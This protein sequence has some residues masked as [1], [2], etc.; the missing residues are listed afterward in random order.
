MLEYFFIVLG[1][2]M[3]VL[4]G[5]FLVRGA[6]GLA[7]KM[8]ITPV[9]VG[10]TIVSFATSAPELIVSVNASM[11]GHPDIAIGNVIGSNIANVGLILGLTAGIFVMPVVWRAYRFDWWVMMASSLLLLV[12]IQDYKLSSIEGVILVAGLLSYIIYKIRDNKNQQSTES[13]VPD[14]AEKMKPWLL[15]LLVIGA[16]LLLRYGAFF[17]VKGAVFVALDMGIEERV[18]SLTIVAFGTSLPE[19][20]ASI[21]AA[22]RGQRDIAIGNVIGSNIFNILS[23]LGFSAM[24][25]DIP[26]QNTSTVT[27][28]IWWML[29]FAFIVWPAMG[30]V[31]KGKIGRVEGIFM[32]SAYIV[33]IA[34]LL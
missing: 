10:L 9:I 13:E 8:K 33:Y 14:G 30:L 1:L 20:A 7:L 22:M 25:I 2:A 23:V 6:A 21:I 12:F 31:T 4:G 15:V 17:L 29:G 24:I 32:I 26:V 34:L 18:V 19:L 5:E 27:F 11:N 16:V 28:D 3:L